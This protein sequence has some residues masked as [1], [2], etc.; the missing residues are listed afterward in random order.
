LNNWNVSI[1]IYAATAAGVTWSFFRAFSTSSDWYLAG[2]CIY[3][4]VG[5]ISRCYGDSALNWPA[6]PCGKPLTRAITE[7]ERELDALSP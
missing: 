1:S 2:H 7:A 4:D 6:S 3:S 5:W